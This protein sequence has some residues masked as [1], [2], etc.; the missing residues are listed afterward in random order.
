MVGNFLQDECSFACSHVESLIVFWFSPTSH[1]FSHLVSI[2]SNQDELLTFV[3]ANIYSV[4]T[5]FTH[6]VFFILLAR[7]ISFSVQF[8]EGILTSAWSN[9]DLSIHSP[10]SCK[11]IETKWAGLW[12]RLVCRNKWRGC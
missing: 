8:P 7:A 5:I 10:H 3:G 2:L 12:A 9:S 6:M 11:P 1:L 4:F